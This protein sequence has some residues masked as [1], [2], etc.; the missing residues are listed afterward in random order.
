MSL[1]SSLPLSFRSSVSLCAAL[2]LLWLSVAAVVG[3]G[4]AAMVL[5]QTPIFGTIVPVIRISTFA[6]VATAAGS[7]ASSVAVTTSFG[8]EENHIFSQGWPE[9]EAI[10]QRRMQ[11][12]MA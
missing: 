6:V 2:I 10:R 1:G 7:I 5:T 11:E 12:M 3:V 4:I 8:G 9:L